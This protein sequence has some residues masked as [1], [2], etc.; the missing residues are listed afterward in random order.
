VLEVHERA[1]GPQPLPQLVAGHDMPGALEHQAED[2][3][4]LF[5][6][7]HAAG[8]AAELARTHVELERSEA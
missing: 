4:R 2:F 6:Q 3:E 8:T 5:L 7:A 1:V